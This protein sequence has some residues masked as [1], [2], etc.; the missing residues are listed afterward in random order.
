MSIVIGATYKFK[1]PQ[2]NEIDDRFVA[3]EDRGDRVLVEDANPY[4]DDRFGRPTCVYLVEDLEI[5]D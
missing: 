2:D 4:W 5:T 3:L 1:M